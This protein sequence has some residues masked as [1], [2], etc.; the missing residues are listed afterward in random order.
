MAF[1][2]DLPAIPTVQQDDDAV[3][4]TRWDFQPGAVTGWHEHGWP[5]FVVML[6]DGTLRIHNGTDITD[7]P[8]VA[9]QSYQRPSGI[10]HDVMNGSPHPIAFVEIEIK[11]PEALIT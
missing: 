3:R 4:I 1:Q 2:C 9:G 11:K 6:M 7:V 8:L 5:Y 10:R